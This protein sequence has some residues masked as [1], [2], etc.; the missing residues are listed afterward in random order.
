MFTNRL[1]RFTSRRCRARS[2][3]EHLFARRVSTKTMITSA[4][5]S[6]TVRPATHNLQP[7]RQR[8]AYKCAL[9]NN[10]FCPGLR[11][12]FY[13]YIPG[14][15]K[16]AEFYS[17][18][19]GCNGIHSSAQRAHWLVTLFMLAPAESS[20]SVRWSYRCR[21]SQLARTRIPA[22]LTN[23]DIGHKINTA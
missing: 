14:F 10:E 23:S 16:S 3:L 9:R 17:S 20:Q 15:V 6:D 11:A 5:N 12:L 8:N 13:T 7:L 19:I 4:T 21:Y 1:A 2:T 18:L 22:L